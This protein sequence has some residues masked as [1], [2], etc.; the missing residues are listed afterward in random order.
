[1]QE[2]PQER[3]LVAEMGIAAAEAC[4]EWTRT[5]LHERK[6]FGSTLNNLQT[7][8]HR[9]ATMK[10]EICIGRKF[11]FIFILIILF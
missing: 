1:M 4:F 10:T 5:F 7:V 9:M 6:A 3:L 11:I 8:K 2:L